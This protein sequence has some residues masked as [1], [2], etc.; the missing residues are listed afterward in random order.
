MIAVEVSG[1]DVVLV[2]RPGQPHGPVCDGL[3]DGDDKSYA[4]RQQEVAIAAW[5]LTLQE[6]VSLTVAVKVSDNDVVGIAG[7]IDPQ[8]VAR[9]RLPGRV[10]R[11]RAIGYGDAAGHS[12]ILGDVENVGLA[13]AV[14]IP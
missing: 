5:G 7:P 1:D 13:V 9:P 2:R 6:D 12:G 10:G 8:V 4:A 14:K 3:R 11:T